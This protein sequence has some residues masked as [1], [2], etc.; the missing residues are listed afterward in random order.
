MGSSYVEHKAGCAYGGNY[1]SNCGRCSHYTTSGINAR[2]H[3][4]WTSGTVGYADSNGISNGEKRYFCNRGSNSEYDACS[5]LLHQQW[6]GEVYTRY[7][8]TPD[9]F[10]N[11]VIGVA[12]SYRDSGAVMSVT[13]PL[14]T[15]QYCNAS[16]DG[17]YYTGTVQVS[18]PGNARRWYVT[19]YRKRT[20]IN[21]DGGVR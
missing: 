17:A 21:Y 16:L 19:Y 11:Y 1:R 10:T 7:E 3:V 4:S 8:T 13:T 5:A 15:E 6:Y 12:G 14:T 20:Y 9:T 2:G 18:Q